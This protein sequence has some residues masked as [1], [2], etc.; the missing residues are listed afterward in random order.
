MG[1]DEVH[2]VLPDYEAKDIAQ[3]RIENA[4]GAE[5]IAIRCHAPTFRHFPARLR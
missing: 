5:L 4:D 3:T 2:F 1:D